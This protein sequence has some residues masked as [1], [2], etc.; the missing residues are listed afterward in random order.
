MAERAEGGSVRTRVE[1]TIDIWLDLAADADCIEV[2]QAVQDEIGFTGA[3]VIDAEA[4]H[5]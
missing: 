5:G 3:K 4:L 2:T 1:A